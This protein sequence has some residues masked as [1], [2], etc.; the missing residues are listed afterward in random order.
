[1]KR[2]GHAPACLRVQGDSK[3]PYASS[4]RSIIHHRAVGQECNALS[5]SWSQLPDQ[6]QFQIT[7][8]LIHAW[9]TSTLDFKLRMQRPELLLVPLLISTAAQNHPPRPSCMADGRAFLCPLQRCWLL[10]T[11]LHLF[12]TGQPVLLG[13]KPNVQ[14]PKLFSSSN[15]A[16]RT[17]PSPSPSLG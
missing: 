1:M 9:Q 16:S 13:L 6:L 4:V 11:V 15:N 12:Y 14:Y 17:T 10:T 2:S 8:H 7:H 3:S 5:S